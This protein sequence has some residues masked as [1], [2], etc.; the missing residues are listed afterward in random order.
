MAPIILH[1]A[2]EGFKSINWG[3]N[4]PKKVWAIGLKLI[5]L[6]QFLPEQVSA[7]KTAKKQLCRP[8]RK[9]E[10]RGFCIYQPKYT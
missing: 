9:R 4:L 1:F 2:V 5:L 8:S 3:F 7:I 10:C 6:L